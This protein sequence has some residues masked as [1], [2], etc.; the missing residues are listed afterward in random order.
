M[1]VDNSIE[2]EMLE[3]AAYYKKPR[4]L[5][6]DGSYGLVEYVEDKSG[7]SFIAIGNGLP[8]AKKVK[9]RL[10]GYYQFNKKYNSN[11]FIVQDYEVMELTGEESIIEYLMAP[12][13]SI[14]KIVAKKFWRIF[15]MSTIERLDAELEATIPKEKLVYNRIYK[16]LRNGEE[17]YIN[18]ME[19]W[20]NH[21]QFRK[22][23]NFLVRYGIS[24]KKTYALQDECYKQYEENID[25]LLKRNPYILMSLSDNRGISLN[26]C[27]QIAKA[28]MFP[29]DSK[30]RILA[31]IKQALVEAL[32]EGHI[33][34]YDKQI[35]IG[36]GKYDLGLIVRAAKLLNTSCE[37]V[38]EVLNSRPPGLKLEKG[39]NGS[40]RIF[41]ETMYDYEV[42]LARRIDEIIRKKVAPILQGEQL[43]NCLLAYQQ[44]EGIILA[45]KQK[46]A[47]EK[48]MGDNPLTIITG[49]AG[50]GKTTVLKAILSI[51]ERAELRDICLVA[52]TGRAAARMAETTEH[53]AS[54]IHSRISYDD[55]GSTFKDFVD[56]DMI[57]ID[58]FSM[59][60][61]KLAYMLFHALESFKRIVIVGDPNQLP[62][63]SA[64]NVLK[65]LIECGRV[66]VVRLDV[67]QRQASDSPIAGNAQIVLNGGSVRDFVL[68]DTFRFIETKSAQETESYIISR[69]MK[70]ASELSMS[71]VQILIPQKKGDCGT[72]NVNSHIQ[73]ALYPVSTKT[74]FRKGDKVINLRN[75]K[76]SFVSNGDMGYVSYINLDECCVEFESG[77]QKIYSQ[78]QL[79]Q[80]ALAYAITV[81]KSQGCEFHTVLI[82][83]IDEHMVMMYKNLLYTAITRGKVCVEL[84]GT[85]KAVETAM[86]TVM[87][88]YRNSTLGSRIKFANMAA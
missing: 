51:A 8:M 82:P 36:N 29:K 39:K 38:T 53:D 58:E 85:Q 81:H 40:Y 26:T 13:F 49:G 52:P 70:L 19:L 80:L 88:D 22:I 61:T 63:V 55:E 69:Y 78:D 84:I 14:G 28:L 11:N 37:K 27:D 35:D 45:G 16:D 4:W 17:R 7:A 72:M 42:K 67:I 75:D 12:P 34:L 15:G 65:D 76:E 21:R 43:E 33:F 10:T 62:S 56:C 2:K 83:A 30:E 20:K 86:N 66:P 6:D 73:T 50:T 87:T 41:L 74:K 24:R 18:L 79:E 31:G 47:I 5:S 32:N 46:E 23:S 60:D 9:Y 77:V 57:V 71:D 25:V 1:G 3:I 44:A 68:S 54:T 59:V 48:I 64:G